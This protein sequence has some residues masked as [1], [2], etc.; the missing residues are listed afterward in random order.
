MELL[1]R[2]GN[3]IRIAIQILYI[4]DNG[5]WRAGDK[6]SGIAVIYEALERHPTLAQARRERS[7]VDVDPRGAIIKGDD[8]RIHLST[9]EHVDCQ[10]LPH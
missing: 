10:D 7:R 5:T 2:V 8:R 3:D 9:P 4:P 1:D 6:L